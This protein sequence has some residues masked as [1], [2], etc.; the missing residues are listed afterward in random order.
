MKLR[1]SRRIPTQFLCYYV[2]APPGLLVT[3][4][5]C[6]SLIDRGYELLPR[7]LDGTTT[8]RILQVFF[9]DFSSTTG[10]S[11]P[12]PMAVGIFILY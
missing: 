12:T 5:S 3:H 11:Q 9:Q 8:I 10:S 1:T 7:I 6:L 2:M 4:L